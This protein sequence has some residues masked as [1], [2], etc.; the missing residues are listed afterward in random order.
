[1]KTSMKQS[2]RATTIK[3]LATGSV[4][5]II[6]LMT[7]QVAAVTFENKS[8]EF[9]GSFDNTF[10]YGLSVRVEDL[11]PSN[12]G[13]VQLDPSLAPLFGTNPVGNNPIFR[14]APGRY[15]VNSDD[16][17]LNYPDTGD[18]ITNRV[19]WIGELDL[20]WKN[21]GAF[22]RADAFYDFENENKDELSAIAKDFV[23][24]RARILDAWIQGNFDIGDKFLSFR[25]GQQVI[26]WGESTFIPGGLNVINPFDVSQLRAAG[27]QLKTAL[28]PV[29]SLWVTFDFSA[30]AY[31]ELFYLFEFEQVD[32]DPAGYYFSTND[33][34]TPGGEFVML[35]FGLLPERFPAATIARGITRSPADDDGQWGAKVGFIIPQLNDTELAFYYLRYHS[36]LPLISAVAVTDATASS[37]EY[38]TE[39][40]EDIDKVGVSWNSVLGSTGIAFQGEVS[41]TDNQPLQ[42][43]DVELLFAALSP[44]NA[45]IGAPGNRFISQLGSFDF[46][47]EIQGWDRHEVTFLQFT[48]TKIFGGTNF[49]KANQLVT[50][51]EFGFQFIGD[52]PDERALRYNGPGTDTGG[53]G[54]VNSGLLRNPETETDGF[55][56]DFSWG[57]R[58]LARAEYNNAIGA[59][60]LFPRIA[61][62]H[63]PGGTSPGPGGPFIE[64]RK[65]LSV[66]LNALYL[67]KWQLD[68]SY[69]RYMGAGRYNLLQDRDWVGAF[70]RYSF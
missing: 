28:L 26:N 16:G 61:W 18:L 40:P 36:R 67:Q 5:F 47:E 2:R 13:K 33:F 54:D 27:S 52:L 9:W 8:G 57:Y 20:N 19:S 24:S 32:P 12:I 60:S 1:M 23:G 31:T 22:F 56:D 37:G 42:I 15:S 50:L 64:D 6:S 48:L 55:A 45:G 65:T 58:L 11:D 41:Y 70:V 39:Y 63:D 17:N 51:A 62:A 68:I 4:A 10:S 46:G 3:S 53:G 25:I 43:D 14:A 29:N 38:F 44:L 66:G 69:T 35:G 49:L 7:A 21:W 59:W 30:M 34:A